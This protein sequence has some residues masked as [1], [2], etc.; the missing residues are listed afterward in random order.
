M[1][2]AAFLVIVEPTL[3]QSIVF[4][5]LLKCHKPGLQAEVVY[6]HTGDEGATLTPGLT[7]LPTLISSEDMT[8][9]L[10]ESS[11]HNVQVRWVG[12]GFPRFFF[13][14][15]LCSLLEGGTGSGKTYTAKR[16]MREVAEKHPE[17]VQL[18]L[19][20]HGDFLL[21]ELFD[22]MREAQASARDTVIAYVNLTPYILPRKGQETQRQQGQYRSN[23]PFIQAE[24]LN[25]FFFQLL[26]VGTVEDGS[27]VLH[28]SQDVAW[29]FFIEIPQQLK[30]K[31]WRC[32]LP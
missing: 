4:D 17:A 21:S 10:V 12:S 8:N 31:A 2:E 19:Q 26:V 6:I 7:E 14:N 11:R 15:V 16:M 29:H 9:I 28:L 30:G 1:E 25:A 3:L 22:Q 20:I 24:R 5:C 32:V 27:R 18:N 23:V 13:C